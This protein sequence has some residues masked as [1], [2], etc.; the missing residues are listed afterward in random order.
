MKYAMLICG[1]EA[2]WAS[3]TPAAEEDVMKEI[4]GWYEKWQPA[5]KVADGGI[6]LQPKATAKT[7]RR[8]ADGEP[9]VTDGP[10]VEL[11]EVLGSVV[12]LEC[13]TIDEAV[14]IASEWPSSGGMSPIEV[15]P[16]M[17]RE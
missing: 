8:G 10:Y 16:V 1:D 5:G 14:Q 17:E 3:L 13:D 2:A 7:I 11:K 4:Y 12:V 9:V 15:R 6:E